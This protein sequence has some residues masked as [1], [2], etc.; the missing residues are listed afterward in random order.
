V[1]TLDLNVEDV[2]HLSGDDYETRFPAL[3]EVPMVVRLIERSTGSYLAYTYQFQMGNESP[4]GYLFECQ[5]GGLLKIF[6]Q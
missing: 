5:T 1:K 4:N 6:V 2:V 3:K